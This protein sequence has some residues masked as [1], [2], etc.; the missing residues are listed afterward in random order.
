MVRR[1][2]LWRKQKR[3]KKS[4]WFSFDVLSSNWPNAH[5]SHH[6]SPLH[7]FFFL[8]KLLLLLYWET[9]KAS[10]L[11]SHRNLIRKFSIFFCSPCSR[12]DSR[13]LSDFW[14]LFWWSSFRFWIFLILFS[15]LNQLHRVWKSLS[16]CRMWGSQS[17]SMYKRTSSRDYSPAVD[18]ED[19]NNSRLLL[20]DDD[21]DVSKETETTNPPWICSLPHVLVATLSSF[22][23][24]YHLGFVI[25]I[26]ILPSSSSIFYY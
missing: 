20:V 19:N 21:D 10:S 8:L 17:S 9:P 1:V 18:V 2:E 12:N 25:I 26:L 4:T 16:S 7:P 14:K 24:G 3:E 15:N 6:C 23:F 11:L 13:W 22:L 5:F